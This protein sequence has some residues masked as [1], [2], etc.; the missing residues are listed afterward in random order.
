MPHQ[1][2]SQHVRLDLADIGHRPLV[3]ELEIRTDTV[4]VRC[5]D[6]LIAEISRWELSEWLA[7]PEG[8]LACG[9][10]GQMIWGW[11][12]L[13]VWIYLRELVPTCF[14][15]PDVVDHLRSCLL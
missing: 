3:A 13:G 9:D 8:T 15:R 4:T 12:G 7:H 6:Q 11:S 10:D 14:L 1:Q 2:I 5:R